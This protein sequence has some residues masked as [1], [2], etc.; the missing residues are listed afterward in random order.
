MYFF[1]ISLKKLNWNLSNLIHIQNR[2]HEWSFAFQKFYPN[3]MIRFVSCTKV[4]NKLD[5]IFSKNREFQEINY[6]SQS[7]YILCDREGKKASREKYKRRSSVALASREQVKRGNHL[8]EAP[9]Q[10]QQ[11]LVSTRQVNSSTYEVS[12]T[13]F[14]SFQLST[15]TFFACFL[16]LFYAA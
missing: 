4:S 14:K 10:S 5:Y 8:A 9:L 11:K 2:K 1:L 6:Y 13:Y 7:V 3:R 12:T 16:W 15:N